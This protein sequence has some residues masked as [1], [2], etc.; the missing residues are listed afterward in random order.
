MSDLDI[1]AIRAQV[2]AM[3]FGVWVE[4]VALVVRLISLSTN[5]AGTLTRRA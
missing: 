1:Q 3:D 4:D 5:E 2:R